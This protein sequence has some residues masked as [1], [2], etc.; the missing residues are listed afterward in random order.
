M[1]IHTNNSLQLASLGAGREEAQ[2]IAVKRAAE[3]RRKLSIASRVIEDLE[4]FSG[5]ATRVEAHSYEADQRQGDD[6]AFGR[7]FSVKA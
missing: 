1:H 2:E 5:A 7:L 3:V 4:A 6:D